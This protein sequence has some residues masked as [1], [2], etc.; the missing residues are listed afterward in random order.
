MKVMFLGE[1]VEFELLKKEMYP[2]IVKALDILYDIIHDEIPGA[3]RFLIT[4]QKYLNIYCCMHRETF[5]KEFTPKLEDQRLRIIEIAMQSIKDEWGD[6]IL[7][8]K[9]KTKEGYSKELVDMFAIKKIMLENMSERMLG[10]LIH[11][12][13][14]QRDC[15]LDEGET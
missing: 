6:S 5:G 7:N 12:Y 15:V 14:Y 9:L 1:N 3:G 2:H 11:E 13:K 4:E 8:S 10:N